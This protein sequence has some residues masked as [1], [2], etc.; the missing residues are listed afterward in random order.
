[1]SPPR[2]PR[3]PNEKELQDIL[4]YTIVALIG[5][6]A[7]FMIGSLYGQGSRMAPSPGSVP[8]VQ[9]R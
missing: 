1:M 2:P 5:M 3:M 4:N 7:G 8:V 6:L 9:S